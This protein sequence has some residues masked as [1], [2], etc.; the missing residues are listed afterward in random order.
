MATDINL[1]AEKAI[2]GTWVPVPDP[3]LDYVEKRMKPT[4]IDVGRA[5]GLYL[6]LAVDPENSLVR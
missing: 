2:D 1:F 3:G 5:H 4:R 6:R